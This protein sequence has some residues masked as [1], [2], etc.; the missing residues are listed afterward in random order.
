MDRSRKR[1]RSHSGG[2]SG[3]KGY[4]KG[5]YFRRSRERYG[6]KSGTYA[7]KFRRSQSR[8]L[9]PRD[10]KGT[11]RTYKVK[12]GEKKNFTPD[13]SKKVQQKAQQNTTNSSVKAT[14]LSAS[15]VEGKN[16][17]E[18]KKE[19][20][21]IKERGDREAKATTDKSDKKPEVKKP[22]EQKKVEVGKL[23]EKQRLAFEYAISMYV[24]ATDYYDGGSLWCNKCNLVFGNMVALCRHL[25]SDQHQVVCSF[26]CFY[27]Y[28]YHTC[29]YILHI[30]NFSSRY[31]EI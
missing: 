12:M 18:I 16:V 11:N 6:Q 25:H 31:L 30:D 7:K 23:D 29:V 8:S 5:S 9:S 26:L 21:E 24:K 27:I 4:E 17:S 22:D 3:Y 10:F 15:E 20:I 2:G 13:V 1:D 14:K 19:V 28:I